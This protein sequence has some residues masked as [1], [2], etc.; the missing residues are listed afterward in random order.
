MGNTYNQK[1]QSQVKETHGMS[2]SNISHH[3]QS[4]NSKKHNFKTRQEGSLKYEV[5]STNKD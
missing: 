5:I 2:P 3:L 4:S 1:G